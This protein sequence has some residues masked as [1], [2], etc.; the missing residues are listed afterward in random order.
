MRKRVNRSTVVGL[1]L[2]FALSTGCGR[3]AL[4]ART[5]VGKAAQSA[6][7]EQALVNEAM[8]QF[9][10]LHFKGNIS[11]E[12]YATGK[13][14]YGKWSAANKATFQ[15]IA[16]WKR[17]GDSQ[18]GQAVLVAIDEAQKISVSLLRLFGTSGVDVTTIRQKVGG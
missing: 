10:V 3:F 11:P 8:T 6:D 2:L 1:V 4:T 12:V 17:I 15:A 13:A 16:A 5:D 7:I 9:A 14:A 18:S